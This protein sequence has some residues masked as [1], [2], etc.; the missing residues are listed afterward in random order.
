MVKTEL[1]IYFFYIICIIYK[2]SQIPPVFKTKHFEENNTFPDERIQDKNC[3]KWFTS[4]KGCFL[5]PPLAIIMGRSQVYTSSQCKSTKVSCWCKVE[6]RLRI[7]TVLMWTLTRT[8]L[9][10][11]VM[12]MQLTI[13]QMLLY[14]PHHWTV[15]S[16]LAM[17]LC[18]F[19][20]L[21]FLKVLTN[22]W[23]PSQ[24]NM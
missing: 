7:K 10:W 18:Y 5:I 15:V 9:Q 4:Q 21:S 8:V 24:L 13:V 19:L 23:C 11:G 14:S 17:V 6:R 3:Q 16:L 20:Q 2:C 22:I 12:S 1:K